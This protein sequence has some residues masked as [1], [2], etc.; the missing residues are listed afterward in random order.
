M[1]MNFWPPHACYMSRRFNPNSPDQT[2]KFQLRVKITK[3]FI[4]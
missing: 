1:C 2:N 3:L 4:L